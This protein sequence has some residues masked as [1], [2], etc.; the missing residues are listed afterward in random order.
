MWSVCA[1]GFFPSWKLVFDMTPEQVFLPKHCLLYSILFFVAY[2][3]NNSTGFARPL[4]VFN[5]AFRLSS[6]NWPVY[7]ISNFSLRSWECFSTKK[8]YGIVVCF[9]LLDLDNSQLQP[10][11]FSVLWPIILKCIH[12]ATFTLSLPDKEFKKVTHFLSYKIVIGALSN[13]FSHGS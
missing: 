5:F 8:V 11:A 3:K 4:F 12:C 7:N 1:L 10:I 6:L 9:F 13:P 2:K